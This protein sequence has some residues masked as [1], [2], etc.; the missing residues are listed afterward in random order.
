MARITEV[1][2]C[3]YAVTI[4]NIHMECL[5]PSV[6][7]F[8]LLGSRMVHTFYKNVIMRQ[9][10]TILAVFDDDGT[11]GG[12]VLITRDISTLFSKTLL[13]SPQDVLRLVFGSNLRGIVKAFFLKLASRTASVSNVPELV[14]LAVS[15]NCR[16]RGY[17]AALVN[18]A[19]E[20]FTLKGVSYYELNV[21]ETNR[22]ALNLYLASGMAKRRS[23]TKSGT[24]MHTLCK[25]MS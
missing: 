4:A 6:S 8:T 10:A 1:T 7:D 9:T 19:E 12:F 17:G 24:L 3:D 25:R 5:P 21:H 15:P 13:A 18:A 16:G 14:Y 2:S 11:V 23:Y 20:W 22:S